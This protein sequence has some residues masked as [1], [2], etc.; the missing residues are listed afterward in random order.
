MASFLGL[1]PHVVA[2]EIRR[3]IGIDLILGAEGPA[4]VG[5]RGAQHDQRIANFLLADRVP[6]RH[7]ELAGTS[8]LLD[9]DGIL[10][11]MDLLHVRGVVGIDQRPHADQHIARAD[12]LLRDGVLAGAIDRRRRILSSSDQLHRH[13]ALAGVRQRDRH[14]PGIEIEHRRGIERVAVH[15][16]DGLGIDRRQFAVVLELAET[17]LLQRDRAEIQIGSR[18]G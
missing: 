16:D 2:A 1:P 14:R 18:R 15:P 13:E 12:L 9:L 10:K 4:G 7:L 6:F 8:G 11:R 5:E 17:A 3:W